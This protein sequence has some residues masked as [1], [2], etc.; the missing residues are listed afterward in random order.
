MQMLLDLCYLTA[1]ALGSPYCGYKLITQKK[2][3]AG[4]KHKL[5][6]PPARSGERCAWFH[7]VSVGEVGLARELVRRFEERFPECPAAIS[8]T[9]DTGHAAAEKHFPNHDIFYYPFD[10]SPAVRGT[11]RR[12]RPRCIV[13]I[14]LE[15][16][17]NLIMSAR[18]K[19]VPVVIVNGRITERTFRR[20]RHLRFI[21]G[22]LLRSMAAISVQEDDYARRL[23]DLGADPEAV[24]VTGNMKYDT[25]KTA[26]DT[27]HP[28]YQ[29]IMSVGAQPMI[30]GGCTWPGEDEVLLKIHAELKQTTPGLGLVLAPRHADRLPAVER[31]IKEAGFSCL[32][33]SS[34]K[35]ALQN[36][37]NSEDM[38]RAVIL[39]DT[40][41]ELDAIYS[42]ADLAFV[43]RSLTQHGGQNILEPAALGKPVVFGPHTENFNEATRLLLDAGAGVRVESEAGLREQIIKFLHDR[44]PF[45]QI[46][47]SAREAVE[48]KKGA[49]EKN[50]ALLEEVIDLST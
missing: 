33:L 35:K 13:L 21:V 26:I 41:G 28:A 7:C 43:G 8:T 16:W 22:P 25:V 40:F 27:D 48:K 2:I 14:E 12:I 23:I 30:V 24:A 17:P 15:L 19:N 46:G 42:A 29:A 44:E 5:G 45:V 18:K 10:L 38:S 47:I 39:V 49:T 9:T 1:L 37:E 3:R 4:M 50:L 6:F 34:L 20:L 11:L 32:R 36:D 31:L